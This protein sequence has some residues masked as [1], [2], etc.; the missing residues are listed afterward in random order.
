MNLSRQQVFD[1]VRDHLLRQGKRSLGIYTPVGRLEPNEKP[2]PMYHGPDGLACAIG[3]LM[4]KEHYDPSVEGHTIMSWHPSAGPT[5]RGVLLS[6]GVDA[7]DFPMF[8]LLMDLQDTHDEYE[9]E[10]WEEHLR[11]VAGAHDLVWK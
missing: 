8:E 1:K 4:A 7:R 5:V 11:R 3:C 6:S 9:P 10:D 2:Y